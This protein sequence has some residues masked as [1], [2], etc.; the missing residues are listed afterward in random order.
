MTVDFRLPPPA[1]AFRDQLRAWLADN[2]T[3][4]VRQA[5]RDRGRDDA[6]TVLRS[7]D[8]TMAEAG[9]AAI[10]WPVDYGGRGATALEQLVFT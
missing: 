8:R 4:E 5:A 10:S 2:L 9:W 7:W 3:D 1:L 6:L